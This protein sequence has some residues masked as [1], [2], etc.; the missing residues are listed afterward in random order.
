MEIFEAIKGRRSCRSYL[1]EAVAES[2][3]EK[4]LEAATWAPSPLNHQPWEFIVITNGEM[5]ARIAENAIT[6]KKV[7]FEKSG[8]K[9]MDKYDVGFLRDVP[10]IIAVIGDPK[11]VGAGIFM[12]GGETSY[13]HACAAAIQNMLLAAHALELGSLW[14][15]LFETDSLRTLLD[16]APEKD[17]LALICIGRPAGSPFQ[18]TRKHLNDKTSY[19]R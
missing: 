19:V 11:K 1:P 18:T 6:T 5:K 12:K 8:W 13:Q 4:L 17:P 7:V 2:T 10:V 14:F 9:W 16:I 3:V 15:T